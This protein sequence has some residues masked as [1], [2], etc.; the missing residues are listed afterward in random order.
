MAQNFDNF[1]LKRGGAPGARD[2][3]HHQVPVFMIE[4]ANNFVLLA[5]PL[6]RGQQPRA[7]YLA[8]DFL[9]GGGGQG[10]HDLAHIT[11]VGLRRP[12]AP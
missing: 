7:V 12:N 10:L 11:A 2:G 5:V 4:P 1:D 9:D 8:E 3:G 6:V